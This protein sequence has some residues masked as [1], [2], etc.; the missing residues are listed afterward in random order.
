MAP[1]TQAATPV[2]PAKLRFL[3]DAAARL[4]GMAGHD[5]Q[6]QQFAGAEIVAGNECGRCAL[7]PLSSRSAEFSLNKVN[8]DN[9]SNNS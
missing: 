5:A 3:P 2:F 9:N 4:R 1:D 8:H 6:W 7:I